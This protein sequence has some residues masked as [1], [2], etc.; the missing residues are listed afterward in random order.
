MKNREIKEK[1]R[2]II[3]NSRIETII[4]DPEIINKMND[5][6]NDDSINA[7]KADMII[8]QIELY[9]LLKQKLERK[10]ENLRYL[11]GLSKELKEQKVRKNDKIRST[12]I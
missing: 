6:I 7:K 8:N 3:G 12:I 9:I 5:I 4:S 2:Q 11:K 1:I 10:E